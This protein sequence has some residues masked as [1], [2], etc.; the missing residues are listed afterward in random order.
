MNK[1]LRNL[2]AQ[3]E[4]DSCGRQ[5]SSISF[6]KEWGERQ[7]NS[8]KR[9]RQTIMRI[10][11]C[12]YNKTDAYHSSV[13]LFYLFRRTRRYHAGW[14]IRKQINKGK[15]GRRQQSVSMHPDM[16][17]KNGDLASY[18]GTLMAKG[19]GVIWYQKTRYPRYIRTATRS[20]STG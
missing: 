4:I 1:R 3:F 15:S 13:Y 8:N 10:G 2:L 19:M 18:H 20:G 9:S 16:K 14:R 17:H 7:V 6:V 12:H 11:S 5:R